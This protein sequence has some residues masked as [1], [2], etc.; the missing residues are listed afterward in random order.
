MLRRSPV[1]ILGA[2]AVLWDGFVNG[3]SRSLASK[4]FAM[5]LSGLRT[6]RN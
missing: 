4:V 2:R 3:V 6:V 5:A 1:S